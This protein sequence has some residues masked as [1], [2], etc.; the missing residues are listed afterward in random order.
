MT[1]NNH[2][3]TVI[4]AVKLMFVQLTVVTLLTDMYSTGLSG[5]QGIAHIKLILYNDIAVAT[6]LNL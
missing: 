4:I 6:S 2:S 5:E 3:L 1:V